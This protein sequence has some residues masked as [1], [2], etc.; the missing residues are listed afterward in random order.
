[1]GIEFQRDG[2][3]HYGWML[4]QVSGSYTAGAVIDVGMGDALAC[5]FW[6]A[7]CLSLQH[8]RC[9]LEEDC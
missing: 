7:Q 2:A 8:S 9:W 5:R 6:R 3:T 4:L 1:M